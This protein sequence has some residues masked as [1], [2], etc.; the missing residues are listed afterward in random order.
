[1]IFQIFTGFFGPCFLYFIVWYEKYSTDLQ[2]RKLLNQ[3]L[4]HICYIIFILGPSA[5]IPFVAFFFVGPFSDLSCDLVI[6]LSRYGFVCLLMEMTLRQ[7]VKYFYIFRWKSI[8]GL[9]D[10]FAAAF[11]T[12]WNLVSSAGNYLN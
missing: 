9:N 10:D 12:M 1:M 3:L 8:V 4:T 2:V 11:L 6:F 7:V 5:R